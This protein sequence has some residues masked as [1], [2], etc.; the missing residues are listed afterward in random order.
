MGVLQAIG[1]GNKSNTT[2]AYEHFVSSLTK[3]PFL[4]GMKASLLLNLVRLYGAD[5]PISER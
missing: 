2:L 3:H 4:P 5:G 1:M